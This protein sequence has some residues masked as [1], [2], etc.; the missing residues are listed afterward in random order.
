MGEWGELEEVEELA[1]K[2]KFWDLVTC[3]QP[4]KLAIK[5]S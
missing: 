2:S 1:L 4:H 3:F 5:V